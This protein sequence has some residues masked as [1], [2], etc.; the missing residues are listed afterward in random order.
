MGFF[1]VDAFGLSATLGLGLVASFAFFLLSFA[2]SL[3]LDLGFVEV[4]E[5]AVMGPKTRPHTTGMSVR[6][7]F[8]LPH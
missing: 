1:F 7:V 2:F 8:I 6:N 4:C 3:A 5:E